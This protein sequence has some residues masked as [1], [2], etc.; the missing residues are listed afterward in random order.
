MKVG[1]ITDLHYGARS[2]SVAFLDFYEKFYNDVFFPYLIENDIKT[3]FVLGDT[4]DRRKYV[5]FY[6]LSRTKQM[7]FDKLKQYEIAVYMLVGNHD[8]YYRTTNDVNSVDLLLREYDNLQI[9]SS[10]QT[11]NVGESICMIPW[12]CPDNYKKC[13]DEIQNTESKICMG[14]FEISGFAM[15]RGLESE[16]GLKRELFRK[17]DIT[18]S[19]HYHHKS[20]SDGIYYVGNPY[21]LTWSDYDD[22]RG[23][24]ILDLQTHQLDFIPNPYEM[25]HKIVYD[26]VAESV[27]DISNKDLSK[28]TQTYV[29]V[30]VLNK[31]NPYIFEKFI[32]RLHEVD[33]IDVTI[34]EDTSDILDNDSV[35]EVNESEDTLCILNKFVDSI[36]EEN[37]ENNKLKKILHEIYVEALSSEK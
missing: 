24:H 32:E 9:I 14:H 2:D 17:F 36:Q 18:L 34:V 3:V 30:V 29:K 35:D 23:F 37:I 28:Y 19:G 10:P 1:I 11:I 4:F 33:P 20:S 21:Q 27:T 31:T 6:T 7:F 22:V 25:F 26:D 16:E 8:T 5:N 15:Y 12:I 13:M